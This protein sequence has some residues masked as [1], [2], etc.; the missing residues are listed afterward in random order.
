MNET[1]SENK[2][3]PILDD[4]TEEDLGFQMDPTRGAQP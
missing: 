4:E 2:Q 3:E 1:Q